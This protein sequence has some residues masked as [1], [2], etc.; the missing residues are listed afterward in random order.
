MASEG[1]NK[2]TSRRQ[3]L[4][5]IG[6]LGAGVVV[7]AGADMILRPTAAP[8]GVPTEVA[9]TA[10]GW[11]SAPAAENY[12]YT[13][14]PGGGCHEECVM[15]TIVDKTPPGDKVLRT[16]V[17]QLGGPEAGVPSICQKGIIS[18]QMLDMPTRILYPMKRVGNRGEGKFERITWDQ[19]MSEIGAKLREIRDKYGPESLVTYTSPCGSRPLMLMDDL[20]SRW[21]FVYGSTGGD[22]GAVDTSEFY[23][24]AIDYGYQFYGVARIDPRLLVESKMIIIIGANPL[25]TRAANTAR[26]LMAARDGGTKLVVMGRWFDETAAKADQFI[27][28]KAGQDGALLLAMA[29]VL[30]DENLVDWNYMT[31]RTVAPFLVREDN[32]LFLRESDIVSD[33]DKTKYV[34]WDAVSKSAQSIAAKAFEFP[35]G[36]AP[37]LLAAQKVKGIACKTA[38]LKLKEHLEKDCPNAQ[39]QE[40]ITG[41]PASVC[42]QLAKDYAKNLKPA[43][44]ISN[45]GYRYQN[46][47][48][49]MR[50]VNLLGALS[51][52]M[53]L[54]AGRVL[55]GYQASGSHEMTMNE[56]GAISSVPGETSKAKSLR[57]REIISGATTGTPRP[58]KAII[59]IC[60]NY[61]ND[62]PAKSDWEKVFNNIDLFVQQ[63]FRMTDTTMWCDYI[64]PDK[65]QFE[66]SDII[67]TAGNYNHIFLQEAAV[68]P[69]G[70]A[71]GCEEF[72]AL[73]SKQMGLDKYFCNA[74]GSPKTNEQWIDEVCKASQ[75]VPYL[76]AV[77]GITYDR[78]KKEKMIRA[79]V[80]TSVLDSFEEPAYI[81]P[82]GYPLQTPVKAG[83][84]WTASGRVEFYSEGL[85]G[86]GEAMANLAQPFING[87]TPGTNPANTPDRTKYPLQFVSYRERLFMQSQFNDI[88]ALNKLASAG[89][90]KGALW[91]NPALAAARGISEG[92]VVEAFNDRGSVKAKAHLSERFPPDMVNI[93][94]G[95]R[96]Q[97]Y[98]G[99]SYQSLLLP[100]SVEYTDDNI[101]RGIT[102][103]DMGWCWDIFW[104]N[105][106]DIRKA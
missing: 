26:Y 23:A 44:F 8:P 92:D 63:E 78:L 27:P 62:F 103:G 64:L 90:G 89:T 80:S 20:K 81:H 94:H 71:K 99:G 69:R 39:E 96:M 9:T 100:H 61:A 36:M 93:S 83:E 74:D 5:W 82:Y 56:Y 2:P 85:A 87:G 88:S 38:F 4:K 28:T 60:G 55:M 15:K 37:D 22:M 68:K 65:M 76:H 35:I 95:W 101:S 66:E 52:N 105:Y 77:A 106:C 18:A 6:A 41:V 72:W 16:E 47:G 84:F 7:G 42:T 91:I 59:M 49:V 102:G 79:N 32:G 43:A 33:G 53:G 3:V 34:W 51:G 12:V 48:R 57:W 73:L 98:E 75:G 45:W 67:S 25:S 97:D 86:L 29:R 10:V 31:N 104:D 21:D 40:K 58:V 1:L 14:C 70:E 30:I 11:Y 13:A 50:A 17:V 24:G 46:G 19:A 54:K